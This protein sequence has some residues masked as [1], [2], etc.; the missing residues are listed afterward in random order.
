MRWKIWLFTL[1]LILSMISSQSVAASPSYKISV[2]SGTVR[3]GSEISIELIVS[4]VKIGGVLVDVSYN[5]SILEFLDVEEGDFPFL[6]S[7]SSSEG[8][9]RVL[10]VNING[11]GEHSALVARIRFRG[12]LNGTSELR[13]IRAELSYANGTL[14]RSFEVENGVV[15]VLDYI[16]VEDVTPKSSEKLTAGKTY[17]FT[18]SLN[19]SFTS[20]GH[21]YIGLVAKADNLHNPSIARKK[22][23][24]SQRTIG[25]VIKATLN[26]D[27]PE[28]AS[29]IYIVAMLLRGEE[30]I[31]KIYD[32]VEYQVTG[33]SQCIIAT[34]TFGSELSPEVKFLRRFRDEDVLSTFAG[35]HFMNVFN[36]FYYSWSPYVAD[37][38]RGSI[39]ARTI[40]KI[41]LYPLIMILHLSS[42]AYYILKSIPELAVFTAG[43]T[44]STLIGLIYIGLPISPI[45]HP[46]RRAETILKNWTYLLI[47]L[48]TLTALAEI[49]RS[50]Y[51]MMI[52][53]SLFIIL[54]ITFS[55]LL[56][57]RLAA[58]HIWKPI[59]ER[60][61][62]RREL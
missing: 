11:T 27:V 15:N 60:M 55:S 36:R 12:L 16:R 48:L 10:A 18:L 52:S 37:M 47:P 40:L 13:I 61:K 50:A 6:A 34:A 21:G 2:G 43:F 30:N 22:I 19:F 8:I 1:T 28:N 29:K 5:R 44:A 58:D 53:S 57:A 26:V 9:V 39:T 59:R 24:V 38:I 25:K 32:S 31:S 3:V 4:G 41:L 51:L 54:N 62:N 14:I 17:K 7:N 33:K 46:R 42:T 23:P 35:R 45:I 56:T 20:L 49:T